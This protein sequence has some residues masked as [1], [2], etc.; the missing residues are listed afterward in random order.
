MI[1]FVPLHTIAA[2]AED[3]GVEA[4]HELGIEVEECDEPVLAFGEFAYTAA[5]HG[6]VV[7]WEC[8][9]EGCRWQDSAYK[10][11]HSVLEGVVG[12]G[13]N[14]VVEDHSS[15]LVLSLAVVEVCVD[16]VVGGVEK[17]RWELEARLME[18]DAGCVERQADSDIEGASSEAQQTRGGKGQT[19]HRRHHH[20]PSCP[21]R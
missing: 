1:A 5:G 17:H 18:Y 8:H 13:W 11:I 7:A 21:C 4:D 16:A 14:S 6:A 2:P 12:R 3:E 20:H 15:T 10:Q 9:F 19:H